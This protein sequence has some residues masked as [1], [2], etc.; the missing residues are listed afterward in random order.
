MAADSTDIKRA[1]RDFVRSKSQS[2]D[3]ATITDQTLIIEEGLISSVEIRQPQ[4][5]GA[6]GRVAM[7]LELAVHRINN[8]HSLPVGDTNHC[9]MSSTTARFNQYA[10]LWNSSSPRFRKRIVADYA[11]PLVGP[12][13]WPCS[14]MR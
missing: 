4:G 14:T 11:A 5:C 7:P 12:D 10:A 6:I 9:A 3:S 13:R 2:D 1:L 8:G